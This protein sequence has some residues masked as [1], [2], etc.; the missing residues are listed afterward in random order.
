MP[1]APSANAKIHYSPDFQWNSDDG[2]YY[3]G[4]VS[5]TLPYSFGLAFHVGHQDIDDNAAWGS[6]D[7]TE[8]NVYLSRPVYGPVSVAVGYHDTNLSSSECFSGL[9]ICEGRAVVAISAAF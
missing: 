2:L 3:E 4:N 7:W 6:P 8:W 1:G 9:N 5:F